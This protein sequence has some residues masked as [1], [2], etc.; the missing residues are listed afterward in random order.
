MEKKFVISTFST[1]NGTWLPR[2]YIP[3]YRQYPIIFDSIE[4]AEEYMVRE[5]LY[6]EFVIIPYYQNYQ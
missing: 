1:E 6:G 4:E 3:T 5:G 2:L